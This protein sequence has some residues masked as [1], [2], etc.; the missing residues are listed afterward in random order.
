MIVSTGVKKLLSYLEAVTGADFVRE[1]IDAIL[2]LYKCRDSFLKALDFQ[3]ELKKISFS[4]WFLVTSVEQQKLNEAQELKQ[5]ASH[6][7]HQDHYL[8]MNKC[9][10]SFLTEWNPEKEVLTRLKQSMIKRE[11]DL[12]EF[13]SQN[14]A[15]VLK[16]HEINHPSPLEHVKELAQ[17]FLAQTKQ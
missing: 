10:G 3:Q 7:L 4:N 6:F 17:M 1:F 8:V 9:L 13:A 16:F 2:A 5:E 15:N 12:Q 11:E 14:F